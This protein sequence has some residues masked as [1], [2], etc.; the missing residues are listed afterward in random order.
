MKHV[1]KKGQQ[2]YV[3]DEPVKHVAYA[4]QCGLFSVIGT[5]EKVFG[6]TDTLSYTAI[7]AAERWLE[8]MS[9]CSAGGLVFAEGDR[10]ANDRFL[11]AARKHYKVIP[12]YL[13]CD[14]NEAAHRRASRA[15]K[16]NLT[17]QSDSWVKGRVTKHA[18]LAARQAGTIKLDARATPEE[19]AA[20]VWE[21]VL[22]GN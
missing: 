13:N 9:L 3:A 5:D 17:L 2:F 20:I 8:S 18:N 10:L 6:G 14:N 1:C 11:E 15:V 16:H 21:T 22:Q 7:D 4:A 12:F 19:L